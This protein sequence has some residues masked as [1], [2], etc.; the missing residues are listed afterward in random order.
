LQLDRWFTDADGLFGISLAGP[1][2]ADG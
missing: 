1:R 2:V